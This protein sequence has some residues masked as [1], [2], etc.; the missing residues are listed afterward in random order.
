MNYKRIVK[1][2]TYGE[3]VED[4]DDELLGMDDLHALMK[5]KFKRIVINLLIRIQAYKYKQMIE[6]DLKSR[7]ERRQYMEHDYD[8][9]YSD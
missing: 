4:D 6:R 8:L 9:K 3:V 5:N 7:I 1:P 2:F